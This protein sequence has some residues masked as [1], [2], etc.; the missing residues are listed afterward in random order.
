MA[1]TADQ[2]KEKYESEIVRILNQ[3]RLADATEVF[4]NDGQGKCQS[5]LCTPTNSVYHK[6]ML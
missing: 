3:M 6:V 2:L 5:L 1:I 4:M